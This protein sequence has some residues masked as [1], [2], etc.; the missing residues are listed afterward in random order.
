MLRKKNSRKRGY[1]FGE[2]LPSFDRMV[3]EGLPER[4]ALS[5]EMKEVR[6]PPVR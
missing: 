1:E 6:E 4:V 5:K 3:S 2:V